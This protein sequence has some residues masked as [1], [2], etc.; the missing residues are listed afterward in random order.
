ME[1]Y[2]HWLRPQMGLSLDICGLAKEE[3]NEGKD[4]HPA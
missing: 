3:K 2:D 1:A 4:S